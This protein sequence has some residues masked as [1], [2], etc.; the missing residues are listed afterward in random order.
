MRQQLREKYNLNKPTSIDEPE[1]ED[2]SESS[3]ASEG[4][5]EEE[6]EAEDEEKLAQEE[7]LEKLASESCLQCPLDVQYIILTLSRET[8]RARLLPGDGIV[9]NVSHGLLRTSQD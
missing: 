8:G 9:L 7:R 6:E 5:S 3:S 1:E 2:Q 4:E